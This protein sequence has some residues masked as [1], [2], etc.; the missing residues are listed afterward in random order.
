M[1]PVVGAYI[2]NF[3]HVVILLFSRGYQYPQLTLFILLHSVDMARS[4]VLALSVHRSPLVRPS[5]P[6]VAA[7][8]KPRADAGPAVLVLVLLLPASP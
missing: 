2:Q 7:E 1:C 5:Y 4:E 8:G 3:V 6:L